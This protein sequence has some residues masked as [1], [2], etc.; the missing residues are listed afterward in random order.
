MTGIDPALTDTATRAA[1]QVMTAYAN[2]EQTTVPL[3]DAITAAVLDVAH[4]HYKQRL[5][6][7]IN[8]LHGRCRWCRVITNAARWGVTKPQP[9][10]MECRLYTGPLTHTWTG[11]NVNFPMG[12]VD[13]FCACGATTRTD[14]DERRPAC[15]LAHETHRPMPTEGQPA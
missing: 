14:L 12:G 5:Y 1:R 7:A 15:R 6:R 10:R 11:S 2:N 13:H 3:S 4:E 9:H 8:E